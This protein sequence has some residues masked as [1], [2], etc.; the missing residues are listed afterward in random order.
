MSPITYWNWVEY[1]H[2]TLSSLLSKNS[3]PYYSPLVNDMS[4][5]SPRCLQVLPFIDFRDF[6]PS[7]ITVIEG[8]SRLMPGVLYRLCA[9]SI[10]GL[11]RDALFI[12]GGNNFD[13]YSLQR[14]A[15]SMGA[16]PREVLSHVHITRAFTEFQMEALIQGLHEAVAQWNPAVVAISYLPLLFF[17]K[18]G[19]RLFG[20]LLE[21]IKLLTASSGIITAVTSFGS[22]W[23]GD[24]LLASKADRVIRIEHP[25]KKCIKLIDNGHVFEFIP[26]PPGQKRFTDFTGGDAFGQNSAQFSHVA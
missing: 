1:F 4:Y 2:C 7:C 14:I 22:S 3:L 24:R 21:Q 25:S 10:V 8:S 5:I 26:V 11:D 15:K 16:D 17:S 6:K 9:V 12:D 18:D 20:P 13:P 19:L 23:E